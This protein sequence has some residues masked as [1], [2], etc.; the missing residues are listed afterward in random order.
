LCKKVFFQYSL[1][2]YMTTQKKTSKKNSTKA[3]TLIELITVIVIVG[4]LT[5][6]S[7][8]YI[9]E[10]VNLW[11][12]LSFRNEVISQGRLALMRMSREIRQMRDADSLAAAS[13]WQL[14]FTDTKST[15]ISYQVSGNNLLRNTDILAAGVNNFTFSYYNKTNQLIT[16]PLVA[17]TATDVYRIDINAT[18]QSGTQSKTIKTKVY[19]RNL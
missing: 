1:Y 18:F 9:R 14:Q 15:S 4:I 5:G 17:P 19:P 8:L 13:A 2:L 6:I 10:T 7:S 12:F 11:R 3:V 16:T